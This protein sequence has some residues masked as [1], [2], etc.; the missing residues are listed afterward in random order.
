M[1]GSGCATTA[2]RNA[3]RITG[4][5]ISQQ[6]LTILGSACPTVGGTL[7]EEVIQIRLDSFLSGLIV[8]NIF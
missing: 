6:R 7:S 8:P 3:P 1:L 5:R 4:S 2:T